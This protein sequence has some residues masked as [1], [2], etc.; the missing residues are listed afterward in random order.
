VSE[1]KERSP[2]IWRCAGCGALVHVSNENS[3]V[4]WCARCQKFSEARRDG[5]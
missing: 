5:G 1:A 3:P 4:A 2:V